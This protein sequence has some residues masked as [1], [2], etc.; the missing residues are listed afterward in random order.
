MPFYDF[1]R[2]KSVTPIGR[3]WARQAA[4]FTLDR[5]AEHT[6][7]LRT[8]VEIGPGRGV[9]TEA[10][11]RRGLC[12][13]ALDANHGLLRELGAERTV[14]AVAPH[15]PFRDGVA[16]AVVASHVLE[17]MPGIAEATGLVA[18]MAR[19]VRPGGTLVVT[20]PDLLWY[21]G[22]FWDCDYSHNF[23]TS[24]RRLQQLF[25]DQGLEVARLE[26]VYNHLTGVAGA[27]AGHA[28]RLVPYGPPDVS[29]S[30]PLYLEPV[31]KARLSFARCVLIIGRRPAL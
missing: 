3:R 9:L 6:V 30:S 10:A 11:Q 18:E 25:L 14:H 17:H 15:L 26:Y 2:D 1:W 27:L 22:Y 20:T 13:T 31:Y 23:P 8:V 7:P 5:A 19:I 28:A 24:A 4:E 29:P 16:D 21:G 12:Y